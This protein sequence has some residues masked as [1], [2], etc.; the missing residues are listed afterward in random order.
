M[1]VCRFK[2]RWNGIA[3]ISIEHAAYFGDYIDAV[4]SKLD[5]FFGTGGELFKDHDAGLWV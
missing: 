2:D 1:I 3:S 4:S 5:G